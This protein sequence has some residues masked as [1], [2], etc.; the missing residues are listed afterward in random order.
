MKGV[1]SWAY[2]IQAI[3]SQSPILRSTK[4]LGEYE[5]EFGR[6]KFWQM[7][8]QCL[9]DKGVDCPHR[10]RAFVWDFEGFERVP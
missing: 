9:Q 1:W 7:K 2:H 5:K 3:H 4:L 10:M 6:M 8:N